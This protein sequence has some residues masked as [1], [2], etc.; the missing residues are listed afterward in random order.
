[1]FLLLL[2]VVSC[3]KE[4]DPVPINTP[5][6]E[7]TAEATATPTP[8]ATTPPE[9]KPYTL[10]TTEP[11]TLK[12]AGEVDK[13][14]DTIIT[15]AT[16]DDELY[17]SQ[18]GESG[19]NY[20]DIT[21]LPEEDDVI[22][23]QFFATVPFRAIRVFSPRWLDQ[24]GGITMKLYRWGGSY[25][26]TLERDP[27]YIEEILQEENVEWITIGDFENTLWEDGEYL[28]VLSD[29]VSPMP[30]GFFPNEY[31]GSA[32]SY[33]NG[34]I[35]EY[36]FFAKLYCTMTPEHIVGPLSDPEPSPNDTKSVEPTATAKPTASPT[37]AVSTPTKA[38]TA[39]PLTT[40]Q[41]GTLKYAGKVDK[42]KD[43]I[44]TTAT[45]DEDLY[46]TQGS[47]GSDFKDIQL[48]PKEDDIVAIQFFS[49]V[50]FKAIR[51]FSPR[52]T[53]P[54]AQA[55][56]KLYRWAGSYDATLKSNSIYNKQIAAEENV[57]WITIGDF[58]TTLWEDGE[59]M[60]VITD[61]TNL[62]TVGFFPNEFKGSARSYV[63]GKVFEHNFFARLYCTMTPEH[64]VGPL[65]D[66]GLK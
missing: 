20:K 46:S 27:I 25:T 56:I 35:F 57:E 12:H 36:N 40:V 37:K 58:S 17:S 28:L 44:I 5:T 11:G 60:I 49:T 59:Y 10:P 18:G 34:E 63:N 3:D 4:P 39:K 9:E 51:I 1:M 61:A 30:I 54:D 22:A 21:V 64:T 33:L 13:E 8:V 2:F 41:P 15:T 48:I 43:S 23:I 6:P 19:N 32:R 42:T 55:T 24:N 53:K 52:W 26:A 16:W 29:A 31:N 7:K 62:M 45:W 47:D 38:P 65:S 50:P 14:K 66:P